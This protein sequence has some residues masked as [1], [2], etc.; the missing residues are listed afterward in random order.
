MTRGTDSLPPAVPKSTLQKK[1]K[2][3]VVYGDCKNPTGLGCHTNALS[4]A[5]FVQRHTSYSV[6]LMSSETGVDRFH[7][8]C[9]VPA[10][11]TKKMYDVPVRIM[12]SSMLDR[13][14]FE[15][16]GYLQ[17]GCSGNT[18]RNVNHIVIN[19]NCLSAF[20]GRVVDD[21][22]LYHKYVLEIAYPEIARNH[23]AKDFTSG[24]PLMNA[25][26][27]CFTPFSSFADHIPPEELLFQRLPEKIIA[28]NPGYGLIYVSRGKKSISN[29]VHYVVDY[30]TYFQANA[31]H[32]MIVALGDESIIFAGA[33]RYSFVTGLPVILVNCLNGELSEIKYR[34]AE[35]EG[36]KILC[37]ERQP[38]RI[39]DINPKQNPA[40]LY[41]LMSKGI[42]QTQLRRLI[43]NAGALIGCASAT[44]AIDILGEGKLVFFQCIKD[45]PYFLQNYLSLI[46]MKSSVEVTTLAKLLFSER[47]LD[48]PSSQ[49]LV[50]LLSN[51]LLCQKL[52]HLHQRL[53]T[54]AAKE[55]SSALSNFFKFPRQVETEPVV[56]SVEASCK[57]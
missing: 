6:V 5:Y 53:V 24:F 4:L 16:V 57:P 56:S 43:V 55:M 44:S 34:D 28:E 18:Q 37:L 7:T 14:R 42:P 54:S 41:V 50:S 47:Q 29:D 15:M 38:G 20:M 11:E 45:G 9:Q 31:R 32:N 23:R 12:T 39:D 35:K 19:D 26:G 22:R 10:S 30:I 13:S 2:V 17:L 40:V 3:V 49:T 25:N 48:L 27:V 46:E 52:C 33:G 1:E 21:G 51:V 8:L 36:K